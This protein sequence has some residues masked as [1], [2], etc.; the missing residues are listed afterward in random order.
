M[1]AVIHTPSGSAG[2][3]SSAQTLWSS[4]A[5][6]ATDE[7]LA[8]WLA[9]QCHMLPGARQ[10]VVVLG[11]ADTGPFVPRAV[12]PA[13]SKPGEGLASVA[14]QALAERV[15][16]LQPVS[17]AGVTGI[18]AYV[19]A[20]PVEMDR[21]LHGVVA[22]EVP[23][24][25]EAHL[26]QVM[27]ELQWGMAWIESFI[28]RDIDS[29]GNRIRERLMIALDIMATTLEEE[30]FEGACRALVTEL[31]L[32]F[33]CDRVSMGLTRD[34]HASVVAISHSADFGKK[35]NL[36][37]AIGLAMDE[38]LDQKSVVQYPVPEQGVLLVTRDH[39]RLAR[40]HGSGSLLTV[41]FSAG[42]DFTGALMLERPGNAPFDDA[43]IDLCQSAM[44]I[45]A[46]IL[47]ARRSAERPLGA[48]IIDTTRDELRKLLGRRHIARKLIL[49]SVLVLGLFFTFVTATYRV[50]GTSTVEGAVRRTLVAPFDGYVASANHR[51]GD[52]VKARSVLAT[53][54]DRDL[55]VERV[56]WASQYAQ[57]AKQYQEAVAVKDRAKAQIAQAQAE[58]ARAQMIIIESQMGRAAIVAPFDG[59]VLK[60]DFSQSLGSAV[61]RGD[62]LFEVAPLDAYRVIL[63]IDE[64]DIADLRK[65]QQG[66]LVLSSIADDQFPF[67]VS[68]I[69][70]VTTVKE[71]GNF[72]RVEAAL[73]RTSESLRPGMEG[74]AKIEIGE[75]RLIW[76]WT[77]RLV[78]WMRLFFWTWWP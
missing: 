60:G 5:A 75:R 59:V 37:H 33:N 11:N 67:T 24:A 55:K 35:M 51:A 1:S 42:D 65:G 70:P 63:Q 78:N 4:L 47:A 34:M 28:R 39:E 13:E 68:N 73:A 46:R 62:T 12:W 72:F 40:E 52:L 6:E 69:T 77:R 64:S 38:S 3:A 71:G 41:P 32:R 22:V 8:A 16:L 27:R 30:T 26:Q 74:V 44:A 17:L 45:G 31:A 48:R 61:K 43:V 36:V 19:I 18:A 76:I 23:P 56:R 50:T 49:A 10:A 20:F 14:E 9:I 58:Q 66:Y 54:D 25:S 29:E 2:T 53:M 57:Y 21:A 15:P 7:R